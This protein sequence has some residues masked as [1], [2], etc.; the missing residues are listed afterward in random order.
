[1]YAEVS[2]SYSSAS[3]RTSLSSA[4]ASSFAYSFNYILSPAPT[5][6]RFVPGFL[7]NLVKHLPHFLQ[8]GPLLHD[9][10]DARVRANPATI[11]FSS[12]YTGAQSSQ[13]SFQVPVREVSD[14][15]IVPAASYSRNWRNNGGLS[16]SPFR[17]VQLRVDAS[18]VRDL[19]NYG[20]STSVGRLLQLQRRTFFG[21]DIGVET[22]RSLN[23]YVSLTPNLG[24]WVRP[25][26]SFTTGFN[27]FRDPNASEP[28]R[29]PGDSAFRLPLAFSN[30]Q[31]LD[32]GTQF[33]PGRLARGLFGDSSQ[34]T[35]WLRRFASIDLAYVRTR[36]SSFGQVA[37]PPT[38]RFPRSR[39]RP[40]APAVRPTSRSGCGPTPLTRAPT[41]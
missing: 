38:V 17:S 5:L 32:A 2:V 34:V 12:S 29:A 3:A 27:L 1:V 28:L 37:S 40:S 9:L 15:T 13:L 21:Q 18:S 6:V 16:F 14:P 19:R 20:D 4:S 41:V 24:D 36:Q 33:D 35:R 31:R 30:S 25:R 23:A 22:Q 26:L 8:D 7:V 39:T 11:Q 10:A